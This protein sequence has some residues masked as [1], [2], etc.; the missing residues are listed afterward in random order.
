MKIFTVID[1]LITRAG[2]WWL[3]R[4][5]ARAWKARTA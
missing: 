2:W 5:Q 4:Q 1:W 3:N